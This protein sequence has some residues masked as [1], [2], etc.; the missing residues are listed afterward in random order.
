MATPR[1]DAEKLRAFRDRAMRALGNTRAERAAELFTLILVGLGL[2][3]RARGFLFRVSPFWLDEC[4][5]AVFLF[6][7]RFGDDNLRPV[8]FMAV[9]EAVAHN[10]SASES[11]LR[12]L[13]WLAGVATTLMAPFIA[14]RLYTERAAQ[15]LFVAI[16]A[17]HPAAIDFAKEFKPYSVSLALHATL[18]L[19][20]LRYVADGNLK[21]LLGVLLAAGVGN[22]FA[23]DLV[24]AYP[25]VFLVLGI[26]ALSR[27]R[28]DLPL[29]IL[30]AAV[31]IVTLGL[32]YWLVWSRIPQ[33]ESNY[34]GDKYNVFHTGVDDQPYVAWLA[35]KLRDITAYPG[36]R[37]ELWKLRFLSDEAMESLRGVDTL[38]WSILAL[39]GLGFVSFAKKWRLLLLLALPLGVLWLFNWLDFWPLGAFRT[40]LFVLIYGA[41]LA[42]FALDRPLAWWKRHDFMPL[43]PAFALVVA[44]L[45][46]FDHGFHKIKRGQAH[47]G[48]MPYTLSKLGGLRL[49]EVAPVKELLLVGTRGC[50]QWE[51][52]SRFHPRAR[53][54]TGVIKQMFHVRCRS[55]EELARAV[56]RA[57]R[58]GSR[59]WVLLQGDLMAES[60]AKGPPGDRLDIVD[61]FEV[62]WLRVAGMAKPGYVPPP[63]LKTRGGVRVRPPASENGAVP[64]VSPPQASAGPTRKP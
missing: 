48:F 21:T 22:L 18:L 27:P 64:L 28:R 37:R 9:S 13:P 55:D 38:L 25:G 51:Y 40:N 62:G 39:V 46:L 30:G 61:H 12:T 45:F 53:E 32:Q 63:L 24:F 31:V 52:Y 26:R 49:R 36:Y 23:Q 17:L 59:V 34:W 41:S 43:V 1:I 10:L 47:E 4:S 6:D 33:D 56:H 7:Q 15:L 44:P 14:R 19:L 3:F 57:A 54:I 5:W 20:T 35:E 29:V 50:P 8:G 58:N 2:L 60:L 11:A 16:I 42:A